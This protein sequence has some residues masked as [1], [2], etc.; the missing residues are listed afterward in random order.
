VIAQVDWNVFLRELSIITGA[1][2]ALLS[3]ASL[4]YFVYKERKNN[5]K[6]FRSQLKAQIGQL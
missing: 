1:F 6:R 3:I 4:G 5:Q 2:G